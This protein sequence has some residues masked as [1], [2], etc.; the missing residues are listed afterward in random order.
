MG[1]Y[2]MASRKGNTKHRKYGR[3]F[4]Y[5]MLTA[6]FTAFSMAWVNDQF[7]LLL[8]AVF[9]FYLT[10]TGHR[11]LLRSI[12]TENAT[13]ELYDYAL[14]GSMIFA[15]FYFIIHGLKEVLTGQIFGIIALIF[16]LIGLLFALKDVQFMRAKKISEKLWLTEHIRRMSAAFL[17][18]IT[19][20]IVVNAHRL[21]FEAPSYLYWLLPS[22]LFVPVIFRLR[23]KYTKEDAVE[24]FKK[25]LAF[26]L[27][28]QKKN[29]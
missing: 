19:A 6:S 25:V 4:S 28:E 11:A 14:T 21:P 7:F 10:G 8:T 26:R 29:S 20:F 24:R 1:V 18:A 2:I 23:R 16:G 13:V 9:S 15:A 17:A 27:E 22:L 5:A 12:N 3:V